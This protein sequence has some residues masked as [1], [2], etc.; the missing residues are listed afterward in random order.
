MDWSSQ[1]PLRSVINDALLADPRLKLLRVDGETQWILSRAYNLAVRA[2]SYDTLIRTDCDYTLSTSFT[3][4]HHLDDTAPSFFAGNYHQSRNENEVHLN[5]AMYIKRQHFLAVGGYDER[6]QTYGWDDEDL[7][8]RLIHSG[9]KKH[10]IS[11]DHITHVPHD[12]TARAQRDVNFVQVEI[13]LNALLLKSLPKWNSSTLNNEQWTITATGHHYAQIH[14]VVK[15]KALKD[16]VAAKTLHEAWD[17]ALGQRLSNDYEIPWDIMQTMNVDSKRALLTRLNSRMQSRSAAHPP[18]V[19]FAHVMHGLGNRLRALASTM[20]YANNTDRELV[21]IWEIDAHNAANFS[22]LFT[23]DLV[24]VSNFRPKWPF[25]GY[26]K[27]DKSWLSFDFFNYMEM[28]G[29]GA[30]KGQRIEDKPDKHLYFK[31]AYIMD[32][33]ERLTN[34]E[35][36]NK[37][38]RTLVP[39]QEV[40]DMLAQQE[41]NG[42]SNMVG[43]HIRDRT[44]DRDIKNVNFGREYGDAASREMEY[45]RRKSSYHTFMMEMQRM[46]SENALTRFYVATDTVEVMPKLEAQ[47]PGKI[48]STRRDCDGRDGRCAR[49]ALVDIL[50]LA[51]T[52]QLLGSNWSS[53]T[54]V[55]SRFGGL[56]PRL[57]GEDFGRDSNRSVS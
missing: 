45:W 32:A 55:A 51:K 14:A 50:C 7:Y 21:V 38:L 6:I 11:Y 48:I 18:R 3:T 41:K 9:L 49:F 53:F 46:M 43:V 23:D 29:D 20:A 35:K 16:I 40:R 19:L 26:D 52:K 33:D 25:K 37:M 17:M 56:T 22:D 5:G 47:F 28:E 30:V 13:D 2:S 44:L 4:V 15:P 10:N 57:A 54:E 39:V 27:Y 8:T 42:L 12:D 1:P 34:W 31:S 24:V 36:D